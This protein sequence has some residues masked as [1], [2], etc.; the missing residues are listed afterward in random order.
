MV[1]ITSRCNMHQIQLVLKDMFTL[2]VFHFHNEMFCI[3]NILSNGNKFMLLRKCM[4][5]LIDA[6]FK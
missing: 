6:R 5:E 4:H 2:K 1:I 3:T